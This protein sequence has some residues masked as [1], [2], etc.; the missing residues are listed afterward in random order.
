VSLPRAELFIGG[1]WQKGGG[2]SETIVDPATEV[3]L[4]EL[5]NAGREDVDA[6]L[7]GARSAADDSEWARWTPRQRSD[8]LYRF[9]EAL[10]SQRQ[11]ILD[12]VV[13]ETGCPISLSRGQQVGL[14][15]EHLE[16]WAEAARRPQLTGRTP[17]VTRRSDGSSTLGSWVV[18]REPYGVVVAITPYNFPLL[19]AVM[20]IGP[21][22]AAGNTVVLKPSPYTPYSALLIAEAAEQAE[23]PAGVLNVV[24]GGADVGEQLCADP[25]VD[26]ISFTGSDLVG[27]RIQRQAA[28]RLVPVLLELGGKS[29]LIVCADADLALAARIG[30]QNFTTHAGQGCVLLTRQLVHESVR[31]AYLDRVGELVGAAVVGDPRDPATTMGPLIRAAAVE[32][33]SSYV[34]GAVSAGAKVITGGDRPPGRGFFYQP[35]LLADVDNSWPVAQD[36]IFGP[37]AVVIGFADED[38]AVTLANASRYGLAGHI[39]SRDTGRAFELACRV[40]AGSID[41]NGGP[42]Y[43]N[44]EVPFG[45]YKRSGI[46][47]ENGVEGLDEYTQLKTIKY[48]AG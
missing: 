48:H 1:H 6:A 47:R 26:L 40:R 43:T 28:S 22:L 10:A 7:A 38:E 23:L 11:R 16:F 27:E 18:R 21:A 42:G 29:A 19:E 12:V 24:T 30:A 33:V 36:E 25:R 9:H 4:G 46:G 31:D 14:P 13:A 17:R 8:A 32:R 15:L 44:P 39:V 35:T 37:V 34:Q 20:K 45:G 5:P 41:L 2:P 3:V